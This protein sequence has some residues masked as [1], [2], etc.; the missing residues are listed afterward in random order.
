MTKQT[1]FKVRSI[2][3][4]VPSDGSEG[5]VVNKRRVGKQVKPGTSNKRVVLAVAPMVLGILVASATMIN[6]FFSDIIISN[7]DVTAQTLDTVD[8]NCTNNIQTY[9]VPSTGKYKIET[10]GA[11]GG[12]GGSG[13]VGAGGIGGKG[14]YTVGEYDLTGATNL[15]IVVGCR[16]VDGQTKSVDLFCG[17]GAGG[18]GAGGG[19]GNGWCSSDAAGGGGGGGL[20]LVKVNA[21]STLIVAGGGG[22]GG[23]SSSTS[24]SG[25]PTTNCHGPGA[26][27]GFGGGLAGGNGSP[28]SAG[29]CTSYGRGGTQTAGGTNGTNS[30]TGAVADG[31]AGGAYFGG[32]GG[33]QTATATNG[34]PMTF[35]GGTGGASVATSSSAGGS[36][37][38]GGGYYGGGGG[39]QRSAGGGG[40]SSYLDPS[41]TSTQIL[42]GNQSIP[43]K[44]SGSP[45]IGNSGNGFVR[46]TP[47]APPPVE[48][49]CTQAVETYTVP[50]TGDYRIETWGAQGGTSNNAAG[51]LVSPG[52]KGGYSVGQVALTAGTT[53]YVRVGCKG[54][55]DA[56]ITT[57]GTAIPGGWNGGGSTYTYTSSFGGG[58]G[59]A[60][61]VRIGTDN[62]NNRVI[63][64]GGGGGGGFYQTTIGYGGYG[65]GA[66]GGT[67]AGTYT[68]YGPGQ[69]GTQSA[70]GLKGP[71]STYA[72]DGS[73]GL[74]GNS[75]GSSG[76]WNGS[77]GGGGWYGGGSGGALGDGGGGGSGYA[78]TSTSYKPSGYALG[79]S[80]YMTNTSTTNGNATMPSPAGGTQTGQPNNGFVRIAMANIVVRTPPTITLNDS[81]P[82]S[83]L[84]GTTFTDPGAT[85]NDNVDGDLT[86]AI[87]TTGSVNT[88]V[89]GQYTLTY[90]VTNTANQTTTKTRTV[91]VAST[92]EF[93]CTKTVVPWTV[94]FNGRYKLDVWG[95]EG[96]GKT[97]PLS[98]YEAQI[99]SIGV[100]G[101]GG[102]STG[103]I[104]LTAGTTLYIAVGCHGWG[105]YT[106]NLIEGGWNGGG[107]AHGSS[108]SEPGG[109]GGGGTD[110]RVGTNSL[111]ARAIVAG[112]GGG[113]GEDS[114]DVYG[115]GGGL[116]GVGTNTAIYNG[117]QTTGGQGGSS[118]TL[119]GGSFGQGAN[120]AL[121]DGGSGGGG[122]YG[123]GI[124]C[125]GDTAGADCQGG[126]GGSGYVWTA[127]TAGSVPGGWLL[128]STKYLSNAST[129]A[130]NASI[131]DPH[132]TG[133]IT[134][135][136]GDGY[137]KIAIDQIA[138]APTITATGAN[139]MTISQGSTF[140]DPGA[141][142]SDA[143]DGDISGSI[144]STNNLNINTPGTYTVTYSVT[145][146]F[147]LTATATRTIMVV[148]N[149]G[150]NFTCT[151]A[152]QPWTAPA[153][154][155]YKLETWG[156]NGGAASNS[157][158]NSKGGYS[159][160]V[161]NLTTGQTI[162]VYVGCKGEESQT[163][164]YI[165]AGGFNG[166]G[167][168]KNSSSTGVSSVRGGGGG[169]TDIRV[170]SDTLY[171]RIIVAGGGGGNSGHATNQTAGSG[172]GT[173]GQA[174]SFGGGGT[175]AAGGNEQAA[176]GSV[177]PGFGVG[178]SNTNSTVGGGGGGWYGG[179]NGNGGG[180]GSGYVLTD[181][182][183]KPSGYF[184]QYA[185]YYL[186]DPI[187]VQPSQTGFVTNP[188][189]D[190][191]GYA[192]IT[193]TT[194][195]VEEFDYTG[196][197]QTW[198]VPIAGNYKLE[199][200][201]AQGGSSTAA[202]GNGGYSVGQVTLATGT[203]LFIYVGQQGYLGGA[204]AG[205]FGGGGTV[206][207]NSYTNAGRGGG[208][209]DVRIGTDSLY[210][211]AIVAGGGGGAISN[212]VG[213]AG[214]G[215]NG[216][217]G[218]TGTNGG[219]GGTQTAGGT[220]RANGAWGVGAGGT[221]YSNGSGGGGWYGGGMGYNTASQSGGGGSGW[222]YTLANYTAGYTGSIYTGGTWL[223][224]T[225]Y[226]LTNAS[227]I[228]GNA[229]MPDPSGPGNITGKTGNGYIRITKL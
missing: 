137:A 53:L 17:G 23:G 125:T 30:T 81:D 207:G 212:I 2:T 62:L 168:A 99:A 122:W 166:G 217:M 141:T 60:S 50:M 131:P 21:G 133:N 130:G 56:A 118:S 178:G 158:N 57:T 154:G 33:G 29:A 223:L 121:A 6:A 214:G 159:S 80:Y 180:G 206:N 39:G 202:G 174:G 183:T 128:N 42:A 191:N 123:G 12:T 84:V 209:S 15:Q 25:T 193:Y 136:S 140:T 92:V 210:T 104:N 179:G 79:S 161:V 83:V 27:G 129:T 37:A 220:G 16:G 176:G 221:G 190:G 134:G 70:G 177:A 41:A 110:I 224:G 186:S 78:L 31:Y 91:N 95:A 105:G 184:S 148:A 45:V 150:T 13:A 52:G 201:G 59:G 116:T 164:N 72:N 90:T 173:T 215:E 93:D 146:S 86:S 218:G 38:G 196:A 68:S 48:Y 117:T 71:S 55:D 151:N 69:G 208:A 8:F 24:S 219:L 107:T 225:Q 175:Q 188:A 127:A 155:Q 181:T 58:G 200:W 187:S 162:Y 4:F 198:T 89:L 170:L 227:T 18:W 1:I 96:G 20:S 152:V 213:G 149:T 115:N 63:V 102:Y 229:A 26:A 98:G 153:T 204:S 171:N 192:R 111:Y 156:A 109:S 106:G 75:N 94:P 119:T 11:E 139:P 100:G 135:N 9:T 185:S 67:G 77:G 144:T 40:G 73:F 182:S 97:N 28:T 66:T 7:V 76:G 103:L 205:T 64:A 82:M 22:G 222:V 124:Q 160:G 61:D 108:V 51:T 85:A 145:N 54:G 172:G 189:S 143:I 147:G 132:G 142:A 197:V 112:G 113:G 157:V 14:G 10:W 65:G 47:T 114:G 138:S 87:V 44:T 43:D 199:V 216:I 126:G 35:V 36:G 163:G 167:A 195:V 19:G 5:F 165:N 203:Q 169:A 88:S 74:G 49:D 228:A 34:N 194:P 120:V 211:R 226:Y 3:D 101:K 46:I 32:Y